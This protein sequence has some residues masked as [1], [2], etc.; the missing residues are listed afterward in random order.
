MGEYGKNHIATA[1]YLKAWTGDD[2]RMRRVKVGDLISEPKRPESAG[3]R[4]RFFGD[5]AL[6]ERAERV[7]GVYERR[8]LEAL[9]RVDD[10]WPVL[11]MGT[12]TDIG[13]LVGIHMIRNPAF[14]ANDER[15]IQEQLTRNQPTYAE[16]M[17]QMQ[18]N[19]IVDHMTGDQFK[20]EH[21]LESVP[22]QRS[23]VASMHW[24]L[25]EFDAPLLATSDHPVTAVPFL[26]DDVRIDVTAMPQAG[27]LAT[28]ELRIAL[29]PTRALLGTWLNDEDSPEPIHGSERDAV[30]L[31]RAVIG[32]ADREWIHHPDRWPPRL[33]V[34]DFEMA[35]CHPVAFRLIPG[36]DRDSAMSSDR[37]AHAGELVN[38][39]IENDVKNAY[40]VASVKREVA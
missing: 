30:Q 18:L 19:A 33:T 20:V 17:T 12:R 36:Y 1:A 13:G 39:M 6:S 34:E 35:Q 22:K 28:S 3:F 29:S 15:M 16:T 40:H 27:Y 7:F 4:R 25:V 10:E 31:N 2:G 38:G 32:Q 9:K 11:D 24:T 5:R 26:P 23:L 37:R 8:G 21:M 14:V